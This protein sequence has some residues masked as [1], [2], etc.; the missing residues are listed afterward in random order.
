MYVLLKNV[1][2]SICRY[3][4]VVAMKNNT[5]DSR[6]PSNFKSTNLGTYFE[7]ISS[8]QPFPYIAAVVSQRDFKHDFTLGDGEN[9]TRRSTGESYYNGPL[10]PGTNYKIFQRIFINDQV[11]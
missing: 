11:R 1:L 7:A 2:P 6:L 8:T 3:F 10:K 9:T 5:E 4:Y